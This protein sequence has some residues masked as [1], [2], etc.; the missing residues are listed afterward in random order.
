MRHADSDHVTVGCFW[1]CNFEWSLITSVIEWDIAVHPTPPQRNEIVGTSLQNML[2][3]IKHNSEALLQGLNHD[4]N[5]SVRKE[6]ILWILRCTH[7]TIVN[8]I[9]GTAQERRHC[10]F[11]CS[12]SVNVCCQVQ[13]KALHYWISIWVIC[14][15]LIHLLQSQLLY[16]AALVS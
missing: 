9:P 16:S 12:V 15:W 6:A 7:C 4:Y 11:S 13:Q 8:G 14:L 3:A 1:S 2:V 10:I 5:W